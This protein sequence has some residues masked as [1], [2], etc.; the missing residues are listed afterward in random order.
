LWRLWNSDGVD[1]DRNMVA[2]FVEVEICGGST[3]IRRTELANLRP[4]DLDLDAGTAMVGKYLAKVGV[5]AQGG[6]HPSGPLQP[7]PARG[8]RGGACR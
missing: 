6:P 3:G 1:G 7:R 2:T 5:E 8:G 4:A